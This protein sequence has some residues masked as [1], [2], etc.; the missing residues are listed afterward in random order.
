MSS[1]SLNEEKA[2]QHNHLSSSSIDEKKAKKYI[3]SDEKK[4]HF[5][6]HNTR[7][8]SR[9]YPH[10]LRVDSSNYE[11]HRYWD[12]GN[13]L[14]SLNGQTFGQLNVKMKNKGKRERKRNSYNFHA[15]HLLFRLF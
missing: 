12:A 10:G 8:L 9:I 14:V 1:S 3:K 4:I 6:R 15:L 13:Q 5:V 2:S 7:Q 11:P